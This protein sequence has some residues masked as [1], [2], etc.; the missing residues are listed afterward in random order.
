MQTETY[1]KLRC[2]VVKLMGPLPDI[3]KCG[4]YE[5]WLDRGAWEDAVTDRLSDLWLSE[6]R[7]SKAWVITNFEDALTETLQSDCLW[8]PA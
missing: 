1:D 7:P 2:E 3:L 8:I 5:V 6:G 4:K